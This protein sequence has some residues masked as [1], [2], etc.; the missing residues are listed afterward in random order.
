MTRVSEPD[1]NYDIQ[2]AEGLSPEQRDEALRIFAGL[3]A[4]RGIRHGDQGSP[5]VPCRCAPSR[6][7]QRAR[8]ARAHPQRSLG[9]SSASCAAA[10]RP[11]T[12]SSATGSTVRSDAYG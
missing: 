3:R 6:W 2:L 11:E 4:S 7:M 1:G 5:G 9:A 10:S 12:R 8:R